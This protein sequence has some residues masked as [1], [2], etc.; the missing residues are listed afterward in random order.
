[1]SHTAKLSCTFLLVVFVGCQSQKRLAEDEGEKQPERAQK[2][3]PKEKA[4]T[5]MPIVAMDGQSDVITR[6]VTLHRELAALSGQPTLSKNELK[7]SEFEYPRKAF[8]NVAELNRATYDFRA[9]CIDE[10]ESFSTGSVE[11]KKIA[12]EFLERLLRHELVG[13]D[14]WREIHDLVSNIIDP[15][16]VENEDPLL[17]G[18]AGISAMKN[19]DGKLA[20]ELLIHAIRTFPKQK[21][22]SRHVCRIAVAYVKLIHFTV[23]PQG[24]SSPSEI[25]GNSFHYWLTS[26]LKATAKEHA[27]V[28]YEILSAM[29]VI[30]RPVR[31]AA[32]KGQYVVLSPNLKFVNDLDGMPPWINAMVQGL[33]DYNNAW[34]WRGN[35]AGSSIPAQRWQMFARL[36]KASQTHFASASDIAPCFAISCE[37]MIGATLGDRTAM[38]AWFQKAY[39]A[40]DDGGSAL[41]I[42]LS[43]TRPRWGGSFEEML[44]IAE[45]V[46][47]NS[48]N[49]E[50]ANGLAYVNTFRMILQSQGSGFFR[51]R[52]LIVRAV[53]A[54]DEMIAV[55]DERSWDLTVTQLQNYKLAL[56]INGKLDEDSILELANKLG[57]K[58]DRRI[59]TTFISDYDVSVRVAFI[60]AT[61]NKKNSAEIMEMVTDCITGFSVTTNQLQ[62]ISEHANDRIKNGPSE[63]EPY[64]KFVLSRLKFTNGFKSGEWQSL[65]MKYWK[66]DWG[67]LNEEYHDFS[68]HEVWKIRS[69]LGTAS[70]SRLTGKLRD[71]FA[72]EVDLEFEKSYGKR[73]S[74]GITAAAN[75][76]TRFVVGLNQDPGILTIQKIGN[77]NYESRSFITDDIKKNTKVMLIVS[78]GQIEIYLN[79]VFQR[80]WSNP[81]IS[82]DG[83]IVLTNN[84]NGG[85]GAQVAVKGVRLKRIDGAPV[86]NEFFDKSDHYEAVLKQL[87]HSNAWIQKAKLLLTLNK[88]D[89]ASEAIEKAEGLGHRGDEVRLLK[90]FLAMQ[91]GEWKEAVEVLKP[92]TKLPMGIPSR[93]EPMRIETDNRV[94][95]SL[96]TLLFAMLAAPDRSNMD[97]ELFKIAFDKFRFSTNAESQCQRQILLALKNLQEGKYETAKEIMN[98]VST[99]VPP[100]RW[101]EIEEHYM[102]VFN[103]ETKFKIG[104]GLDVYDFLI[105]GDWAKVDGNGAWEF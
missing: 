6:F 27:L 99:M 58:I 7:E 71:Y 49:L 12:R 51:N 44:Q 97:E 41:R 17:A 43:Y 78:E 48:D 85:G 88:L 50:A 81:E 39:E 40:Q 46:V 95:D 5:E 36:L 73:C 47:Q 86:P 87:D 57:D 74:F 1:M 34:N 13:D 61:K 82:N 19:G 63:E 70:F 37:M 64:W 53:E 22:S 72:I 21:Y 92:D 29:D 94:E 25:I 3:L 102:P 96:F 67:Q 42:M 103:A 15:E 101:K 77:W 62:V 56:M 60:A 79:G 69:G 54:L 24:I 20:E 23:N 11:K 16:D 65:P 83:I 26:D 45:K 105:V 18:Y 80:T 90:S 33:R 38:N 91:K 35:G 10:Y 75:E 104:R 100:N 93:Y 68:S 76:S 31:D 9:S 8:A 4:L 98:F 89:Q 55:R 30:Y 52:G 14:N 66:F 59:T 28:A 32:S 2:V 84:L